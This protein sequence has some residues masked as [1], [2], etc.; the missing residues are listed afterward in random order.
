MLVA[1]TAV[2]FRMLR[3]SEETD[4]RVTHAYYVRD[5]IQRVHDDLVDVETGV[6]GYLLTEDPEFLD[7]Y[8]RGSDA[9]LLDLQY[10]ELAVENEG[11]AARHLATAGPL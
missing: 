4:A 2:T 7:P 10:L 1:T 9:L 6:R 3:Q 11:S 5:R 8:W